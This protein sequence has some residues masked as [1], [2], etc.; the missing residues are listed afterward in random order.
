MAVG[1]LRST[2]EVSETGRREGGGGNAM[3][4]GEIPTIPRDGQ[5]VVTKLGLITE[6][7]RRD[8]KCKFSTLAY[9][10]NEGYLLACFRELKV[11]KAPGID[12]VTVRQYEENLYENIMDLASRLKRKQYRPQPGR[13]AYIPKDNKS[14]RPLGIP[15]VE[16]KIVQ[17]GIKKIL[18]SI[19]EVDFRDISYGFRL[20]RSHHD[21]LEIVDKAIMREPVNYIVDMDI[22]KFFD[23]V[24]HRWMMECL[25]Q[26]ISDPS[27]LRL[28]ARFLKAGIIEEGNYMETDKG[29][30]QGGI[31]SP[32]LANIYLH[33]V[34]DLWYE[35]QVKKETQGYTQMIR[36]ADD[37]IV[38]FEN[39]DEAEGFGIKLRERLAKF[40]L[41]ISEEKSRTIAYGRKAWQQA[42]EQGGKP[43][44]FD[45][46]GFTHYCATTRKGRFRAGRQTSRKKLTQKLK[47]MNQWLKDIRNQVSLKEW[48][49]TLRQKLIGHYR[50]YGISGNAERLEAYYYRTVRLA[51][52]WINRRSQK[53]SMTRDFFFKKY[54]SWNP[55]PVPKI[56]H[57]TY[58]LHVA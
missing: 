4:S 48:W 58:T 38:C 7:A 35:K 31:V 47:A 19:Y 10:L 52:K 26:R 45:F 2:V 17:M 43:A 34:L 12:G 3:S 23:S 6:R 18:E 53:K 33:Y 15:V 14:K 13:R 24:D 55:L 56:Y 29:T 28:I 27:F 51:F 54:L 25:K 57:R 41:R 21:A 30:P 11:N 20:K 8:P 32:V 40:G 44:T 16:D 39:K 1:P 22:E 5:W 46:L 37:F 50:Y 9:L 36:Y 42:K 49:K